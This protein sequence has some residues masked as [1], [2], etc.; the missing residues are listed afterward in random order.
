M[1]ALEKMKELA[2]INN[3]KKAQAIEEGKDTITLI[4]G[5][6]QEITMYYWSRRWNDRPCSCNRY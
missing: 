6:G 1:T 2:R 5:L 4:N 3:E